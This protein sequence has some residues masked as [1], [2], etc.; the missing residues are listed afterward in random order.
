MSSGTEGEEIGLRVRPYAMTGGRTRAAT[1]LPI[2]T[3]LLVT[4]SGRERS[5]KMPFEKGEIVRLC[6]EPISVAEVSA[7]LKLPLGVARVLAG[8]LVADGLLD[9]N[10][11]HNSGKRPDLKLLERVFDGL[12][13]L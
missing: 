7:Y 11:S 6:S 1:D 13:A 2:E 10:R 9:F 4:T 3:I 5:A 8:D 12:Q